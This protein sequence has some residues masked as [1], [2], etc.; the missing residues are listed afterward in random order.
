L[1][2]PERLE[3]KE[4]S[5][6]S[7]RVVSLLIGPLTVLAVGTALDPVTQGY[8]YTFGSV[9]AAAV[10]FE[11]GVATAVVQFTSY[12]A[13]QL[14]IGRGRIAGDT[15]A[16]Q[17][18][19]GVLRFAI[20]WFWSVALLMGVF[21]L[22]L[23]LVIFG[24]RTDGVE[25]L[26]PWILLVATTVASFLLQPLFAFLEGLG[27]ISYVYGFRMVRS[28][29]QSGAVIISVLAG[30]DLYSLPIG[31]AVA[32]LVSL[33]FVLPR[34]RILRA[35]GWKH[36]KGALSWKTQ[37]LP[38]QWRI[39]VSWAAGYFTVSSFTPVLMVV[40]G[41]VLAGQ[42][43]MSVTLMVACT[44]LAG[45]F[46]Q[47]HAPSL[48]ALWGGGARREMYA[49]FRRKASLSIAACL[50]LLTLLV[51][52]VVVARLFEWSIA[53]RVVDPA[54][55]ALLAIGFSVYHTEGVL[56]FFMRAQ[57]LEP[58]FLLETV[59]AL[60]IFPSTVILGSNFGAFGVAAGFALAHLLIIGPI[61]VSIFRRRLH[62]ASV[63]GA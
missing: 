28:L 23:G 21:I 14:D 40:Q 49:L 59:G 24:G 42:V 10:F 20:Y 37:I 32:L 52:G 31:G 36:G 1:R 5:V 26:T 56:A 12:E 43:G 17:R 18:L 15:G 29:L 47:A 30:A 48:G 46:V 55:L 11:A 34:L 8:Y 50:V 63:P 33:C 57:K 22:V 4:L 51:I 7:A 53:F 61:A 45:S 44:S 39:A 13:G 3:R 25:W 6:L 38:F 9:L 35:T 27:L 2:R 54:S 62:L 58:Y 16:H 19:S 60:V 41:P